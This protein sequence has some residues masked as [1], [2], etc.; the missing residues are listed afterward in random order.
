MNSPA[1]LVD[2][3]QRRITYLRLSVTDRCDLRCSYCMPERMTFLPRKEVLTLEELHDLALGFIARGITKIRLT[4]GEPLVRR[5][6]MELVRALGRKIGDGLDE[7]TLTTNAT[8][9]SEF[10]DDLAAAG[11]RRVNVSLDTLDRETFTRLSRRDSLPQV[12]EGLQAAKEAG[13]KVKLNTVALKEINEAEIPD[14]I[15][16][17]HGEGFDS[18]LIEVMPLGDVE[19]DRF[20][21]YLPLVAVQEDLAR[22]WTLTPSEHRTGGPA[23]Y[24]NVEETGGRIGLITPLT[25]NFCEG[26]NRIRVTAT[27]QL[28]ACLGGDERVDLRAALRSEDPEAALAAALDTAMRIKPERHHFRIEEPGAAPAVSRHMSMT[29]G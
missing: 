28:Y 15:A 10:A 16:W 29:G 18:T 25:N 27:G 26:C 8:R 5:D 20:D 7:L 9:L 21:H 12:L 3:F 6:M 13:L 23:R 22:R 14:L 11:V 24:W 1:P 2:Q 19:E 17:A 4:G